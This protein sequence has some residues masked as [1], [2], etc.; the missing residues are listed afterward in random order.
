MTDTTAPAP[1]VPWLGLRLATGLSQREVERRLGWDTR[2]HLSL[3]ERG[4]PPTPER[5]AQLRSFY[6]RE[7]TKGDTP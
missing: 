4:L 7:L 5:A 1:Q 2:G 6:G 3:I